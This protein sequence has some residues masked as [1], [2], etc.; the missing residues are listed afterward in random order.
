MYGQCCI[1][2]PLASLLVEI[3]RRPGVS[4]SCFLSPLPSNAHETKRPRIYHEDL[5]LLFVR[6][7]TTWVLK[8]VEIEGGEYETKEWVHYA[9]VFDGIDKSL[10]SYKD[11]VLVKEMQ[12]G[13]A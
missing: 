3:A 5:Q 7:T 9:L 1:G 11:G 8:G 6:G 2:E 13:Y 10:S 4:F 12:V